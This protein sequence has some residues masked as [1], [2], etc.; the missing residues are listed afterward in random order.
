ML[1]LFQAFGWRM[2]VI[3]RGGSPDRGISMS[4]WCLGRTTVPPGW[5]LAA[6][7]FILVLL[8]QAFLEGSPHRGSWG[9]RR[10]ALSLGRFWLFL[11]CL[12]RSLPP[13]AA[14]RCPYLV[15]QSLLGGREFRPSSWPIPAAWEA[16][17]VFPGHSCKVQWSLFG[18][19]SVVSVEMETVL[20]RAW[21]GGGPWVLGLLQL[22]VMTI[23]GQMV[24]VR[25]TSIS[26]RLHRYVD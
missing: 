20:G 23:M 11:Q 4:L 9:R 12:F 7:G 22:S 3:W 21:T 25:G 17:Q 14:A 1:L 15:P 26:N 6:R 16:Y 10:N 19:V 2:S 13:S 8:V 18:R 24:A 5:C